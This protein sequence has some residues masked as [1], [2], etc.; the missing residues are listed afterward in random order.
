MY[1]CVERVR[2]GEQGLLEG[3]KM[4][5]VFSSRL[6]T[7]CKSTIRLRVHMLLD[8]MRL[9][10]YLK[11]LRTFKCRKMSSDRKETF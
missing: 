11:L 9:P 10:K 1:A 8:V 2:E 4:V 7:C 3:Y 5:A 6:T